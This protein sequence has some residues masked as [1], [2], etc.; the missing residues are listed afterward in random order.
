MY[1]LS[2]IKN[3]WLGKE[4]VIYIYTYIYIYTS[5]HILVSSFMQV[6]LNVMHFFLPFCSATTFKGDIMS[7]VGHS[8]G[9]IP[10]GYRVVFFISS[11]LF[12]LCFELSIW[13]HKYVSCGLIMLPQKCM[14]PSV[15]CMHPR[16]LHIFPSDAYTGANLGLCPAN[17]TSLHVSPILLFLFLPYGASLRPS[18]AYMPR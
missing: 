7:Y 5:I 17:E 16:M 4:E 12:K 10:Q 1:I 6:N 11:F 18:D 14:C 8:W 2:V 3:Y 15:S 13:N 9:C